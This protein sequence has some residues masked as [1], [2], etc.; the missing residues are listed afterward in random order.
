M[1][2]LNR[3]V[4]KPEFQKLIQWNDRTHWNA[5]STGSCWLAGPKKKFRPEPE[6]DR[7]AQ[8][9]KSEIVKKAERAL[10]NESESVTQ[11]TR[12]APCLHVGLF[13]F[14]WRTHRVA[15][16]RMRAP[17]SFK[18]FITV[19][20]TVFTI[21]LWKSNQINQIRSKLTIFDLIWMFCKIITNDL[22]WFSWNSK[23]T[24][25]QI[26]NQNQL[27]NDLKIIFS[28]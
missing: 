19:Q 1:A 17:F 21:F 20:L 27:Q 23:N 6:V 12:S 24:K 10:P 26:K 16:T 11:L 22:I 28:P 7:W 4:G 14:P 8:S 15:G 13:A 3:P 2:H 9:R 18:S 25:N 5:Q